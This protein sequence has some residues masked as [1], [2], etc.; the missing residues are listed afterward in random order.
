M[1][2]LVFA[3]LST[4]LIS[5][6]A[7]AADAPAAAPASPH[8]VA[9]NAAV[10]SD[11]IF[12]GITQTQHN[13]AVSGGVDYSHASG[14][15]AGAWISNQSWVKTGGTDTVNDPYK[16]SSGLEVDLYGGYKGAMGDFGYDL[17]AIRYY[18]DGSEV[19]TQVSPDTT[20][21]YAAGTWKMLTLKYSRA[22]SDY[23]IGWGTLGTV[24]TK[25]SNYLE[26]NATHDLG[27]GLGL[28]AHVGKQK[29][30]NIPAADYT[31]WKVGVTKDM[32]V[33]VVTVA[34]SDTDAQGKAGQSYSWDGK[35]TGKGVL[36][37]SF[38]KSF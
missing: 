19:S 12:R 8:T 38:S 29:V 24:K 1:K 21:L 31:D 2:K 37:V 22:V 35:N 16:T 20:E 27:N 26:L 33:G 3:L 23:F 14:I 10:T 34:Y 11:Y 7:I 6:V 25:G 36:A 17:G 5:G 4:G 9:Y 13:P 30:M 18:Y 32:G 28:I 15:Y